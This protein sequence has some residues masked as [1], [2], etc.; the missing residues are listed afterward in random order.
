MFWKFVVFFSKTILH[1]SWSLNSS[2]QSLFLET[3]KDTNGYFFALVDDD[4][5]SEMFVFN[6]LCKSL[7]NECKGY[8]YSQF[9]VNDNQNNKQYYL[10]Y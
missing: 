4:K 1:L 8:Y 2:H 3:L 7:P 6:Q 5:Q 9:L 10:V